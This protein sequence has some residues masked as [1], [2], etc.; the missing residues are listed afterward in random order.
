MSSACIFTTHVASQYT[1]MLLNFLKTSQASKSYPIFKRIFLQS[2]DIN[3]R[4]I[5][6]FNRFQFPEYFNFEKILTSRRFQLFRDFLV[7]GRRFSAWRFHQ[8]D[9]SDFHKTSPF[10]RFPVTRKW[11]SECRNLGSPT[12]KDSS[13]KRTF[14]IFQKNSRI[15]SSHGS[16]THKR[17]GIPSFQKNCAFLKGFTSLQKNFKVPNI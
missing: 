11:A 7:F 1:N 16:S 8:P 6:T 17:F 5:L 4:K 2:A 14:T 3:F 12:P 10:R 15:P 9:D 13:L